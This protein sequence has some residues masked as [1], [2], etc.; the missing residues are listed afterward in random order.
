MSL[1]NRTRQSPTRQNQVVLT[2]SLDFQSRPF[3]HSPSTRRAAKT[4]QLQIDLATAAFSAVTVALVFS[5]YCSQNHNRSI[6][7]AYFLCICLPAAR[8]QNYWPSE[9]SSRVKVHIH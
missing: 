3:N 4:H 1:V 2:S 8:T 9:E 5:L 6:D 7:R